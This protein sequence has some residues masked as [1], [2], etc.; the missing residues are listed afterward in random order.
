MATT[1]RWRTVDVAGLEVPVVEI[2]GTG[3]G[4]RLTVLAGV[5]GCE[6]A[7]MAAVREWTRG[8]ASRELRGKVT[9]VPVLNLPA[10]RARTPFVVPD[11]GKNLNRCFPGDPAG[12]LADRLAHAVFTEL[13]TGADAVVDVH[14][15]DMVEALEPFAL[16]DAGPAEARA[17]EL[18]DGYGLGYV[19]RQ[20]PGPDRAVAGTTSAAAAE[21]GVPAIIAEAGG[22]GLVEA[23]AVRAHV[24]GLDHVLAL[25]G[26]ASDPD[27]IPDLGGAGGPGAGGPVRLGRFL[28]LRCEHAGWWEPGVSAGQ[29][30]SAGSELGVVGSLDGAQILESVTAPADGTVMFLT[31]S[32]AVAAG[33]LLLGL[34]AR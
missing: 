8:L 31:T 33:G 21:I 12:T 3:A 1:V 17:A 6:Y 32:P 14:A 5:H 29:A 2:A 10:F 7:P 18:A 23:A 11:D 20:Q 34:G 9:A 24:R 30:V 13:I 19:I 26:M 16:Y 15:G 27:P 25:L 28:W 4:P 22:C